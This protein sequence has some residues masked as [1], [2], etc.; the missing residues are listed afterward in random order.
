MKW[1]IFSGSTGAGDGEVPAATTSASTPAAPAPTPE[2]APAGLSTEADQGTGAGP[3][4]EDSERAAK[5]LARFG[6]TLDQ[7]IKYQE[8][9]FPTYDEV[10]GC[11]RLL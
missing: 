11:M 9:Q 4:A 5:A 8:Q 10:P 6:R 7:E 3:D 1:N 2:N